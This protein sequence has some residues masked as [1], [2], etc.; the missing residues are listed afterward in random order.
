MPF[1]VNDAATNGLINL[2]GTSFCPALAYL[3]LDETN[4][5]LMIKL[6]LLAL[7]HSVEQH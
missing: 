1:G 7:Q 5:D 6:E 2:Y 3:I 4:L